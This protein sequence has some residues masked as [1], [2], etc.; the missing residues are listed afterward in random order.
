MKNLD[1]YYDL[2]ELVKDCG[3]VE[4]FRFFGKLNKY[5][6]MTP[7]GF[8][9]SSPSDD[10]VECKI[11]DDDSYGNLFTLAHGYKVNVVPDHDNRYAG[12][13]FYQS[14]LLS[15][16]KSGTFILKTNDGDHIEEREGYEYLCGNV[17]L[18]HHWFEVV[19]KDKE[20]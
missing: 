15:L 19:Q 13:R 10:W 5:D 9:L 16:L 4:K 1:Q 20:K 2:R 12:Y 8:A 6:M 14:D 18:H 3:G 17:Y 11:K 7:F